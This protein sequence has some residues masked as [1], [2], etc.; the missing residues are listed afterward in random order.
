MMPHTVA[1][2]DSPAAASILPARIT[3]IDR[4]RGLVLVLMVLDHAR[5]YLS[6][7][8][9]DPLDLERTTPRCF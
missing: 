7:P 4:L 1:R 5:T 3:S 2:M 8:S 6:D 9:F